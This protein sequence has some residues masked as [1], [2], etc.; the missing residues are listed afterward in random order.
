MP[1]MEDIMVAPPDAGVRVD[2]ADYFDPPGEVELEIGCGK[3]GFLLRRAREHPQRCFLGI[4]WANKYYK[5]AADRMAR[6]GVR[7]V[8]IVR[9]DARNFVV[10]H[11]VPQCL[12][13]LHVY[14]PDPWPKKRHHK[15]RL[16]QPDF[17]AAAWAALKPG[18]RWAI[19]TDHAEYHQ[20]IVDL[21]NRQAGLEPIAYNDPD[22]GIV[23]DKADTNYEIKY[24]RQGRQVYRLAYRKT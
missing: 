16:F 11:L 20:W 10:H 14:H 17:V 5:Y 3:G 4:E 6:W 13:A 8:R 2:P 1:T 15:R 7:N 9:T 23:D 12:S 24:L 22:F 18:G 21:M 19:Q